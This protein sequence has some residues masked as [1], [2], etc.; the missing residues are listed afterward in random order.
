MYYISFILHYALYIRYITYCRMRLLNCIL[1]DSVDEGPVIELLRTWWRFLG[2]TGRGWSYI[3]G[4]SARALP[5]SCGWREP[6]TA[7]LLR[8]ASAARSGGRRW[9]TC[10]WH[11]LS[12]RSFCTHSSKALR[13]MA[14]DMCLKSS[15]STDFATRILGQQTPM[16]TVGPERPH[17]SNR[18]HV[19]LINRGLHIGDILDFANPIMTEVHN[20]T[21]VGTPK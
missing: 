9:Q 17:G 21:P 13:L 4:S 19:Q 10:L 7:R 6:Q 5:W 12:S 1:R 8:S 3:R 2:L 20:G 14:P 18:L 16:A 15:S 11:L